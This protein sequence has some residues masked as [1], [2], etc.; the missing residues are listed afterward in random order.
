MNVTF[1][2]G[3]YIYIYIYIERASSCAFILSDYLPLLK[4]QANISG[5]T[6]EKVIKT[7][8]QSVKPPRFTT[9]MQ[10]FGGSMF[11]I[12]KKIVTSADTD[13]YNK[14]TVSVCGAFDLFLQYFLRSVVFF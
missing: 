7:L 4:L 1:I 2:T 13:L 8:K 10:E 6:L 5:A 9:K 12:I 14:T 3:L 11:F